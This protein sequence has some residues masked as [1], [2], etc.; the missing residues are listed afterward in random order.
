TAA[1]SSDSAGARALVNAVADRL[2]ARLKTFTA[3]TKGVVDASIKGITTQIS[4]VN[5]RIAKGKLSITERE[6]SLKT[7]YGRYQAQIMTLLNTQS[8]L[9]RLV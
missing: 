7:Q 3:T 1:F 9:S 6:T 8:S 5:S 2:Q 4:D